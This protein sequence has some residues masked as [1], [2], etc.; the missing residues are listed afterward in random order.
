MLRPTNIVYD[1]EIDLSTTNNNSSIELD[2][3]GGIFTGI[4][5]SDINGNKLRIG[6][7][8][9]N[10]NYETKIYSPQG[11][12]F[13]IESST[14]NKIGIHL[15]N[16]ITFECV[17]ISSESNMDTYKIIE[18]NGRP[19]NTNVDCNDY[20]GFINESVHIFNDI[21]DYYSIIRYDENN[22]IDLCVELSLY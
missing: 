20:P 22:G 12:T 19:Y 2:S 9:W 18:L 13:K 5:N 4:E 1:K 3:F 6:I 10:D 7:P 17:K 14:S 15:S 16:N 11:D 21:T 8:K